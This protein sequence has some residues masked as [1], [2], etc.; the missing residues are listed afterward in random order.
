MNH[1]CAYSCKRN[2]LLLLSIKMIFFIIEVKCSTL[3]N[4]LEIS[5]KVL[6]GLFKNKCIKLAKDFDFIL[7]AVPF[8][9]LSSITLILICT[10]MKKILQKSDTCVSYFTRSLRQRI[11]I[12]SKRSIS[13]HQNENYCEWYFYSTMCKQDWCLKE[14]LKQEKK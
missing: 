10:L 9:W 6:K 4:E 14:S 8:N 13:S 12:K 1:H 5:R 3:S 2:N 7:N 11:I